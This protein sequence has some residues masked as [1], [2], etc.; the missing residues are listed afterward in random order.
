M[1]AAGQEGDA[2]MDSG[3]EQGL[4]TVLPPPAPP[5]LFPTAVATPS[6]VL[7]NWGE[8]AVTGASTAGGG[9]REGGRT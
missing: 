5:P 8:A 6:V 1:L 3:L 7:K 4:A 2:G 9:R